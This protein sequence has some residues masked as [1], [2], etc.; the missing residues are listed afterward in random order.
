MT[1][2]K[3]ASQVLLVQTNC[4]DGETAARI[5]AALVDERLVACASVQ[6]PCAS[7][8]RW[9]GKVEMATETPLLLKIAADRYPEVQARL[10]EMHPYDVPE[11][12]AWPVSQGL[13]DY[14]DWVVT[15]TRPE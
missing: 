4:P 11:I 6:A 14:L 9:E 1:T 2:S 10:L 8:Y 5:A 7:I 13:P 12:V 15:E 3:N